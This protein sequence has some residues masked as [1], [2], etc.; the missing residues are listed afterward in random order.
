MTKGEARAPRS[1]P[2]GGS[3]WSTARSPRWPAP[4][5]A[6]SPR[7]PRLLSL[8]S[9]RMN[10]PRPGARPPRFLF[11]FSTPRAAGAA[12]LHRPGFPG[13][14]PFTPLSALRLP[15]PSTTP[16]QKDSELPKPAPAPRRVL[17]RSLCPGRPAAPRWHHSAQPGAARF[18]AK[19]ERRRARASE[20]DCGAVVGLG[21]GSGGKPGVERPLPARRPAL[22]VAPAAGLPRHPARTRA[23]PRTCRWDPERPAEPPRLLIAWRL[24]VST[25]GCSLGSFRGRARQTAQ[26]RMKLT[27]SE[28]GRT[29]EK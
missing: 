19:P 18:E 7:P 28:V 20:C 9:K 1:P 5:R 8:H 14:L 15:G 10:Q 29:G 13:T 2:R 3:V 4:S 21:E 26:T 25:T 23:R 6:A 12:P 16:L 22:R 24:I 11:S 17:P 27:A